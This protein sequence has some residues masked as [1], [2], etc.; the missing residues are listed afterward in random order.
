MMWHF[1]PHRPTSVLI[2]LQS[3]WNSISLHAGAVT[4][5]DSFP[6]TRFRDTQ[7]GTNLCIRLTAFLALFQ[8]R[9]LLHKVPRVLSAVYFYAS[10]TESYER[11][12]P[13]KCWSENLERRHPRLLL[14]TTRGLIVPAQK[15]RS[16]C[17]RSHL[18]HC[19]HIDV[20]LTAS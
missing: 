6:Y 8:A 10:S 4:F 9:Y 19:D 13:W 1:T 20:L 15:C 3:C 5:C 7:H 16:L 11:E 14:G 18:I 17:S 12:A 2:K